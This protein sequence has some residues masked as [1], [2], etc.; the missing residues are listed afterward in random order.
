MGLMAELLPRHGRALVVGGGNVAARKVRAL[1]EASFAVTVVAPEID[2]GIRAIAGVVCVERAYEPG[3]IDGHMLVFACTDAR[4]VN[5]AVGEA[6]RAAGVLV[7][8][9]DS[10]EESTFFTPAVHREGALTVAVSTGGA[11]PALARQ[12]LDRI[13]TALGAGWAQRVEAARTERRERLAARGANAGNDD[14]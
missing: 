7:D 9:T 12:V 11:S 6:A 5:R 10:Q 14:E 1:V 3:D 4:D 13:V 8:V 2:R